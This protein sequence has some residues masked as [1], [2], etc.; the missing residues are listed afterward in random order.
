[1]KQR[2]LNVVF[3]F[4]FFLIFWSF[5]YLNN[6]NYE[7]LKKMEYN[8][9]IHPELTPNKDFAKIT[10][11]WY[12]NLK[13]DLYWLE[14]I[15]YIW[16]NVI[17]SDYKKYLYNMLDLITHL[18]PFFEKPYI[19]GQL[20]LPNYNERYE[21]LS[22]EKQNENI[23][24]WE[25]IWLKWI[26]NFCDSKKI[27]K[28]KKEN[29]LKKIWSQEEFKNPCK[30]FEIPFWQ[31]FLY[32]YYLKDPSSAAIYYKIASANENSNEWSK[33]MA[34]IMSGKWWDREKSIMMFLTLADNVDKNDSDFEKCSIFSKELQKVSFSTFRWKQEL[35]WE[36]IKNIDKIR[37]QY[38][39]FSREKD[40]KKILD[41]QN[42]FNYINKAIRELNLAYLDIANEKYFKDNKIFAKNPNDLFEKKYINFI[43]KDFQQYEN[44]WI[45]YYFN[46]DTWYFDY[47]MWDY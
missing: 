19:I 33:V 42:C 26:E 21:N 28:I 31:A 25:K 39:P 44:Y 18:N 17:S 13:A 9:V 15:Q 8:F 12:T 47:K 36:I 27:E 1:M 35:S 46:Q 4:L 3:L 5:Y 23:I 32:Y 11:F 43:P 29:D 41:S 14:T 34:A 2:I 24:Q 20:L 16:S 45:I 38:F 37:N 22:K 7:K 10:S 30:S 6:L 40:E